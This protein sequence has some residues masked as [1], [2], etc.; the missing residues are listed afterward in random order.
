MIIS[1]GLCSGY[2]IYYTTDNN[3]DDNE[4]TREFIADGKQ[5]ASL[6]NN[7]LPET[8]Y[9]FKVQAVDNHGHALTTSDV[10]K[11][12]HPAGKKNYMRM[13]MPTLYYIGSSEH[14]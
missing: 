14:F 8:I 5:V 6:I 13:Y 1:S 2:N 10:V 12:A 11:Y 4:W 7:M 9:Y 3:L